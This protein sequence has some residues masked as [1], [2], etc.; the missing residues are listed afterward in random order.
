M[1]GIYVKLDYMYAVYGLKEKEDEVEKFIGYVPASFF[2]SF[3]Q[4]ALWS[5]V[6]INLPNGK[7]TSGRLCGRAFFASAGNMKASKDEICRYMGDEP[8][9]GEVHY[10]DSD[11]VTDPM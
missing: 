6:T 9:A 10:A 1:R 3:S 8:C 5:V 7:R 2:E 4:P 11:I